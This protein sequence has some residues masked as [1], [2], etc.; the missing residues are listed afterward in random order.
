MNG[1]E[2]TPQSKGA[3]IDVRKQRMEARQEAS[4]VLGSG[5]CWGQDKGGKSSLDLAVFGGILVSINS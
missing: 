4:R 5:L 1:A 3:P 2:D